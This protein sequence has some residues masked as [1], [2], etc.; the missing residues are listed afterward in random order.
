MEAADDRDPAYT[1]PS[2][3]VDDKQVGYGAETSFLTWHGYIN[4]EY[5]NSTSETANFDN[6][7][8]YL[9]AQAMVSR[10]VSITAEFEYEHTPEKLTAC[11]PT[12]RPQRS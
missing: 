4:F 9:S 12:V 7:E 3:A 5:D 2:S 8:F 6:H 1:E 10:R 11:R